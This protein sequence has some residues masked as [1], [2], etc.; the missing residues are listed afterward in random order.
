MGDVL[1]LAGRRER[2]VRAQVALPLRA[3]RDCLRTGVA[4]RVGREL[5]QDVDVRRVRVQARELLRHR[6]RWV[7]PGPVEFLP[8][9]DADLGRPGERQEER[10]RSRHAGDEGVH[11]FLARAD[12]ARVAC[13]HEPD[14]VEFRVID[15]DD[16]LDHSSRG[17]SDQAR[18]DRAEAA[19]AL[20]VHHVQANVGCVPDGGVELRLVA[21]ADDGYVPFAFRGGA[22]NEGKRRSGG[23]LVFRRRWGGRRAPAP[24]SRRACSL[25]NRHH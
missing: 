11:R 14:G 8:D 6:H 5:R 2:A 23:L 17:E 12:F 16:E 10:G 18:D 22:P 21:A 25:V 15:D 13:G 7:A 4:I 9:V 3:N 1:A 20:K 24:P 19:C